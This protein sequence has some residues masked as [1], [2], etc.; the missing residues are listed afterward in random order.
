MR[1][2]ISATLHLTRSDGVNQSCEDIALR[3]WWIP[4]EDEAAVQIAS[5][6]ARYDRARSAS[7]V[8]LRK[9]KPSHSLSSASSLSK[10]SQAS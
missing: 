8:R 10:N 7:D 5:K 6:I 2:P 9:C 4:N 3:R 1:S